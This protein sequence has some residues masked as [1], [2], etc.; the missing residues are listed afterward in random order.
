VAQGINFV[1]ADR[2][3]ALAARPGP[4]ITP[5][6]GLHLVSDLRKQAANALGYVAEITGLAD[7]AAR[8]AT[9]TVAVVDRRG[10]IGGFVKMVNG[11]VVKAWDEDDIGWLG[12]Q[13]AGLQL[14]ALA[15]VFAQ[16]VLGQYDPFYR[17]GPGQTPGRIMLVA[18]NILRFERE[19]DADPRDFHLWITL[20][21]AAHAVQFAAAPWLA[22]WVRDRFEEMMD[23]DTEDG[24]GGRLVAAARRLPD[25]FSDQAMSDA[26]P[27]GLLSPTQ[28]HVL[29]RIT[30]AMSLLEGHADVIMDAVG[31]K[32]VKSVEQLRPRFDARRAA[33]GRLERALRRLAGLEAKTAQYVQGATFVRT[34]LAQCGHEGLNHALASAQNLPTASEMESPSAWVDRVL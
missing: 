1:L 31:P 25:L 20:H 3:G 5:A 27:P 32:V 24:R 30:G 16:R 34:V 10:F 13:V 12:G 29:A 26:V 19:L 22:D 2:A 7:A 8:A 9:G 21:E 14:G 23:A 18:P 28:A 15:G 11:L 33:R 6:E 17:P 4:E